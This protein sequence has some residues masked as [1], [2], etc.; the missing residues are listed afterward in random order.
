MPKRYTTLL[1]A[2]AAL[3]AFLGIT[4]C[5]GS[6]ESTEASITK[7]RFA[8]K[9]D[10]IC[11]EAANK[12]FEQISV[13]FTKHLGSASVEELNKTEEQDVAKQ[14]VIP[15]LQKALPE[16]EALPVPAGY[17]NQVDGFVEAYRE[18]L[19]AVED[20]PLLAMS[21]QNTPFAKAN[22]LAAKYKFGDCSGN[23]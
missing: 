1:L 13:Y 3:A 9:A 20:E 19:E 5:G 8:K 21:E 12:Q 14:V 23:P 18:A 11:T 4:G 6:D 16:L 7:A 22:Q 2:L 15:P 17:E 10:L